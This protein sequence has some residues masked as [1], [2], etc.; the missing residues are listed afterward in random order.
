[1]VGELDVFWYLSAQQLTEIWSSVCKCE[2]RFRQS[3]TG[4]GVATDSTNPLGLH[5]KSTAS[6]EAYHD[7]ISPAMTPAVSMSFMQLTFY[8][9]S[10][11]NLARTYFHLRF[12][13]AL[14]WSGFTI[15]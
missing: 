9:T 10:T 3:H 6:P 5:M 14:V 1:M 8:H 13:G 7:W 11:S 4:V 15:P 12:N 2:L